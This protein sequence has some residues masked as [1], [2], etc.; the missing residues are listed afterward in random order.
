[1]PGTV[2]GSAGQQQADAGDV[3]SL[4]GFRH[5]A[6]DDDVLDQRRVEPGACAITD[7]MAC[8]SMSS[9]R[10]WPNMPLRRP[11]GSRVAAT[12]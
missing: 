10:T 3:H 2:F 12:M 5:R 6:A 1:M 8:A 11:T 4:L 7:R 9:G